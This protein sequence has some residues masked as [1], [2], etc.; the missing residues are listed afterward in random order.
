MLTCL[1]APNDELRMHRVRKHGIDGVYVLVVS[2]LIKIL[3]V[4]NILVWNIIEALPLVNFRGSA[5]YDSRQLAIL[6]LFETWCQ[7]V[8][9]IV[10]KPDKGNT[11]LSTLWRSGAGNSILQ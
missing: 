4:V 7:L 6:R 5:C 3:V 9:S 10:A 11:H 8:L 1:R 2:D